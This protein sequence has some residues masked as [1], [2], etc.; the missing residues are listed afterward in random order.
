M[1]FE[2]QVSS[3]TKSELVDITP[4][5]HKCIQQS[6]VQNGVCVLF[7]PHTTAGLTVNENWDPSVRV[8]ILAVLDRLVPWQAAYRHTEGNAAAHVKASLLGA[9]QTLLIE[10]G[11]L[12]LGTWQGVF[13]A[14]FDGPR[15]RE[16]WVS[17]LSD[18]EGK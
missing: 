18:T 17:I 4:E 1:Q 5:V 2:I 14:E 8:D 3:K 6:G 9:S 16:V 15:R 10:N 13:L 11:K 7:V 12:A